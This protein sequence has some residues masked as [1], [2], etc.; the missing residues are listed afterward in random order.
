MN[1]DG[2]KGYSDLSS[3]PI[4]LSKGYHDIRIDYVQG[5]SSNGRIQ[6]AWAR[7]GGSFN[8]QK[9]TIESISLRQADVNT[10]ERSSNALQYGN[11]VHLTG[12]A[13][14]SLAGD[15]FTSVQLGA[16]LIDTGITLTAESRDAN[17]QLVT[18]NDDGFGKTLRF[19]LDQNGNNAT[20][21]LG[22]STGTVTLASDMNVAF[23][24]AVSDGSGRTMTL[25]RTG[26]GW[27][28][29]N[30]TQVASDLDSTTIEMAGTGSLVLNGSTVAGAQNPIGSALIRLNGGNLILD[31][32]GATSTGVGPVFD[33]AVTI[34]QNATIQSV[35][36]A[37]NIT[38]GSSTN[39]ITLNAGTT[40]TL[41]AIAGGRSN[42]A[43]PGA[44][45]I[46]AGNIVGSG[47]LR[48]TSTIKNAA[49]NGGATVTN[50]DA[51]VA[52]IARVAFNSARGTVTLTGNNVG[53]TGGITIDPLSILRIE[54]VPALSGKTFTMTGGSLFLL[55]DGDGTGNR[56]EA[57]FGFDHNIT[58]AGNSTLGVGRVGNT[59]Y[60]DQASNKTANITSL[61][62]N[63]IGTN[64]GDILTVINNNGYGLNVT[65]AT[66][67][68]VAETKI[69]VNTLS[70]SNVVAGFTLE[71]L[72]SGTSN[73]IK[74]GSGT[75]A[76][77]N[78]GNIFTGEVEIQGGIVAVISDGA[79]G[80][81]ANQVTLNV[82]ATANQG[83]R[84]IG[85]VTTSR[86]INL[87][88]S[89]NV[90]EV[91]ADNTLTYNGTFGFSSAGNDLFKGDRG[92]LLITGS[93]S[94]WNGDLTIT[95]GVVEISH[96]SA[97]GSTTGTTT[98]GNVAAA[99]NLTGDIN[100]AENLFFNP[101]NNV[102]STGINSSGAVRSVSG[103]NTL[104]GAISFTGNTSANDQ[105][106]AALIGVDAGSTLNITGTIT[107]SVGTTGSN[108]DS[109]IG[110]V[111]AGIGTISSAMNY[112][113]NLGNG[114]YSLA[115][116]GSGTW[117]LTA[118][119]VFNGQF[120]YALEGTLALNGAGTLGVP[121]S[122]GGVG[123][124]V[125]T[126]GAS[127]LLDNSATNT[128]NRLSNRA[129]ILYGGELTINGNAAA[130]TTETTTGTLTLRTGQTTNTLAGA[131]GQQLIAL[132]APC[133]EPTE[134]KYGA[135]PGDGRRDS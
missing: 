115:K 4:T 66:M 34:L 109:W 101:G 78:S 49:N 129:L 71:G 28:S 94:G 15:Q 43:D 46:I 48:I 58:I 98:I 116:A 73:I 124:L 54:G 14:I 60:Y 117:N 91:T 77:T 118:A 108:R 12:N 135:F 107:G 133:R 110:L 44:N 16:L 13:V 97:L 32:K 130:T 35:A 62:I 87:N 67:L 84:A 50:A 125:M 56:D 10:A 24:G 72:V 68:N 99:L 47:D 3:E 132:S 55:A 52:N 40:L 114:A 31:S 131:G 81:A 128:N 36:N 2:G 105:N 95:Q 1:N 79:L 120:V 22:T 134:Q 18:G 106:R 8:E 92:T 9:Q 23:D 65:G 86:T 37:S 17:D 76:L 27:L 121:G 111:G 26:S 33:N 63:A 19:G 6:L 38:L 20:S 102:T 42:P 29:F 80:N 119:N 112:N 83:L 127:V 59:T 61:T 96:A 25:L 122:G 126:P 53:F 39:G 88:V 5:A 82:N 93:Q 123:T 21:I 100:L 69:R 11:D 103:D 74:T 57:P 51:T 64:N 75:L 85:N 45:L 7:P 70:T 104:S 30:Q 41:D 90:I 113:G 89:Q